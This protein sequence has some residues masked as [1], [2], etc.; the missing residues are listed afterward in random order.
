MKKLSEMF[1]HSVS[2]LRAA[3]I[4]VAFSLAPQ[5]LADPGNF[6]QTGNLIIARELH[7]ATLLQDGEVIVTGGLDSNGFLVAVSE[8]YDS[9]K[10]AW[11]ETG[12]LPISRNYHTATLLSNGMVLVAGGVGDAGELTSAEL[13]EPGLGLWSETGS[14][15]DA[16]HAHTATLLNNGQVLVAGGDNATSSEIL[17]SCELYDPQTGTWTATGDLHDARTTHTATLLTNG[18]VL[19]AGGQGK[20]AT[21]SS[22]E[23]YDPATGLWTE[24][25]NLDTARANHSATLLHDG[26]VLVAGGFNN[27]GLGDLDSSETYNPGTASWSAT[28]NLAAARELHTANLLLNGMVLVAG[29]TAANTGSEPVTAELYDPASGAWSDTG[30]LAVGRYSHTGTTLPDGRVVI[31]GG[32]NSTA[33][34]L[35]STEL[36]DPALPAIQ[37]PLIATGTVTLPFSYQFIASGASSL[38]VTD[39][40]DGLFYDFDLQAIVGTPTTEGTFAVTLN[41]TNGSGTTTATLSLTIQPQPASGPVVVSATSATGR[42]GSPFNFQVVTSGGSPLTRL[43]A[44]NLPPG[45]TADAQTGAITGTVTSD[46]SYLVTLGVTDMG[47]TNTFT[48]ELTFTS[49]LNVPVITSSDTTF[50]VAGEP[51]SF[52]VQAP[53][54][55]SPDPTLY[56]EEG[57]LP[58]GL[59]LNEATGII[60]GVFEPLLRQSIG[61]DLAGGVVTNVQLF[62]CN[63]SGC[64]AQGLFFLT[65]TGAVNIST[66]LS[67]GTGD[68]VLIGGFI[69]QGNAPA[70]LVARGIGPSLPVAGFLANPYLE[71]H[72]GATVIAANDNWKV[73]LGGGSQE[74]AIENTGLAP[75]KDFES[76]ILSVLEPGAYTAVMRGVNNGVGVGLVEIYN[77]GAA[78]LDLS[79]EAHLANISTRGDVQLGDNVMIGGFINQSSVPIQVLVRGI[80][81]S[82][83]DQ[84]VSGFLADPVLE[85]HKPDGTVVTNDNWGAVPAEK[86]AIMATT[87]PPTNSKESAIL[88]TLPVGEG[89]YTAILSGANN[90]TG[91]GL[92]EA[93]FG[94]PCIGSSCP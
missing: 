55:G 11:T 44:T 33:G 81:P 48:L 75:T 87:I 68:N 50:L 58:P 90:T 21:L 16:R 6:E 10:G 27:N 5:C 61:P 4:C 73:N 36:Y 83:A 92:V 62:A 94:D 20:D 91:V 65:P 71:L 14:L 79:S 1:A 82:L 8:L 17:S 12:R 54:P 19:V 74:L 53:A 26:T 57:E 28:G 29:G 42:T 34:T 23:L 30:S 84:G 35:A 52:Q 93:Y 3:F 32:L 69:T 18:K 7:T 49:N 24:T 85:L 45:L 59:G 15:T 80:G 70:Q 41:A 76:A 46:G 60:A 77:L 39:L 63:S 51:F 47:I 38:S 2:D 66:R 78:S 56:F 31:A 64:G 13:Y 89:A 25:G 72:S 37:S 22:A 67:V 88:L 40:P 86:T 43:S 9:S